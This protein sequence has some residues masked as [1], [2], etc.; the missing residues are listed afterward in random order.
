MTL[1]NAKGLE[2]P[3]VFIAGLEEGLFPHSRS[4]DSESAMEEERRLCYVGMTRAETKLYLSWA[5][6]R[7][8]FGG[9]LPE[10]SLPS[11]FLKEVPANLIQ[12]VRGDQGHVDL[13]P[14]AA[15]CS[16]SG[17]SILGRLTTSREHPAVFRKGMPV[18]Q[19]ISNPLPVAASKPVAP[20]KL[21]G[22]KKVGPGSTIEHAKYGRG[23]VLRLEGSGE[24]TKLTVNFPGHGLKKLIAKYAGIKV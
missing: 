13:T 4:L 17:T 9:G 5:R 22:S 11:R 1:H 18:P 8:R 2:F 14:N 24:D 20:P 6:Y 3:I 7:R 23:T 19:G 12:R 16:P 10:V 21:A 15:G